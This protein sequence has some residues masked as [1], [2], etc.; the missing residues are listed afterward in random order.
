MKP[1]EDLFDLIQS[2]THAE[3]RHFKLNARRYS[4]SGH[5]KKYVL[6]FDAVWRQAVYDEMTLRE[7]LTDEIGEKSFGSWKRHLMRYVE[8]AIREFHAGKNDD[9][10]VY[11]K[12]RDADL[13]YRRGLWARAHKKIMESK[14]AAERMGDLLALLKINETQRRLVIEFEDKRV[15]EKIAALLAAEQE[16]MTMLSIEQA[17]AQIFEEVCLL[18]RLKFDPRDL[19]VTQRVPA[20]LADPRLQPTGLFPNFRAQRYYHQTRAFVFHLADLP[21]QELQEYVDLLQLWED[22]PSFRTAFPKMYKLSLTNYLHALNK[23][24]KWDDLRKV[25]DAMTGLPAE[26]RDEAAEDFQTVEFYRLMYYLNSRQLQR[27]Q[28]LLPR[29][30]DGL[31]EFG[32]KVNQARWLSFKVNMAMTYFVCDDRR[33]AHQEIDAVLSHPKS[34][35][36]SDAQTLARLLEP[37]LVF[38]LGDAPLAYQKLHALREW[39]RTHG[40]LYDFE[41]IVLSRLE[42]LFNAPETGQGAMFQDLE[43]ALF[44]FQAT[45]ASVQGLELLLLWAKARA[46]GKPLRGMYEADQAIARSASAI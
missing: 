27:A 40:R 1:K 46:A 19:E 37:L 36:R 41:R 32:A 22:Q 14:E 43:R 20:L 44:A 23:S 24:G 13:M 2:M 35:H 33:R 11:E 3:R 18:I 26:N 45:H 39:L 25:L 16:I 8:T 15:A 10:V 28:D 21:A 6:L 12:L 4:P 17:Y 30:E 5:E 9:E 38:D 31:K 7:L 29:I 42:Q 34:E